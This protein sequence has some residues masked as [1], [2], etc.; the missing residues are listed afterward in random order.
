MP[1]PNNIKNVVKDSIKNFEITI[2]QLT[3]GFFYLFV[4]LLNSSIYDKYFKGSKIFFL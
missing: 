3:S 4:L 2:D 1:W